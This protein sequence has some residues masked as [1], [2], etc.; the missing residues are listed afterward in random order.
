MGSTRGL[1]ARFNFT[2][3]WNSDTRSASDDS[4]KGGMEHVVIVAA[5]SSTVPSGVKTIFSGTPFEAPNTTV[6][7]EWYP[8]LRETSPVTEEV[9]CFLRVLKCAGAARQHSA[10]TQQHVPVV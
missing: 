7:S 3:S 4:V 9:L 8:H 6:S 1:Y 5:E 10:K 2:M